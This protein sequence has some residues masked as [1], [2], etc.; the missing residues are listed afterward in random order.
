MF[1]MQKLSKLSFIFDFSEKNSPVLRLKTGEEISIE[2]MDCFSDQI[3]TDEDRLENMDWKKIN[4]AT[5][6]VYVEGSH[7]GDALKVTIKK[8]ILK[9]RAVLA[10]GRDLGVLGDRIDGLRSKTVKITN[11]KVI[12]DEKLS[13]PVKPMIGVIGV[14]PKGQAINCGTPGSH[15]GNMDNTMI[16]E[17]AV[18]YLP[19]FVEGAL[20][21]LGDLHAVMGNGEIGVSGAEVAG[22]VL[23]KIEIVKKAGL[24]N[25]IVETSNAIATVASA[26]TLDEAVEMAVHDMEAILSP[27][28][29]KTTDET[30][31]LLS[32][33]ANVEI[34]QVVD[35][36]KTA[37]FVLPKWVLERYGKGIMDLVKA[38]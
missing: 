30:A 27:A 29:G 6:P 23:V 11:G 31:M 1:S 37:R 25:P 4:P 9:D 26:K 33:V 18:L 24:K 28:I 14:A 12:F 35:P 36:M 10:T 38:K 20:F 16:G 19:V 8:I 17:G 5:G 15:G 22:D 7:S 34:C 32:L 21:A 13:I 2:T 3:R